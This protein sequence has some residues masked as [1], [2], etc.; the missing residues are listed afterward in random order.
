MKIPH[1]QQNQCVDSKYRTSP[2]WVLLLVERVIEFWGFHVGKL[3]AFSFSYA[4]HLQLSKKGDT[5][6]P[7]LHSRDTI[8]GYAG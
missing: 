8:R 3:L 7:N 6:S 1:R 2:A 5:R 4:V